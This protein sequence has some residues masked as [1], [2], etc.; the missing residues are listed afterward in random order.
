MAGTP[1]LTAHLAAMNASFWSR[2]GDGRLDIA[3]LS[4]VGARAALVEQLAAHD[5]DIEGEAL[6]AI[7]EHRQRYPYFIQHLG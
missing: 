1:G 3:L 5:V 6:H 4:Y 7:I 2:L